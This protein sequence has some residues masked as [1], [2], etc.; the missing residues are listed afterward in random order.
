[1][2]FST[3]SFS[4]CQ[5]LIFCLLLLLLATLDSLLPKPMMRSFSSETD[6]LLLFAQANLGFSQWL[7][8]AYKGFININRPICVYI[9]HRNK[10]LFCQISGRLIILD[11]IVSLEMDL[12]FLFSQTNL[13]LSTPSMLISTNVF[14]VSLIL[15]KNERKQLKLRHHSSKV[16]FFVRFLGE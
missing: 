9:F 2:Y 7:E 15:P 3:V 8:L 14:L 16:D 4:S 13:Y 12:L 11:V 6:L 1:M 5:V 10:S